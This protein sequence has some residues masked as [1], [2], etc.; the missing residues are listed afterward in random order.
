MGGSSLPIFTPGSVSMI[1]PSPHRNP[2]R[3]SHRTTL[4]AAGDTTSTSG[5]FGRRLPRALARNAVIA[6]IGATG[7]GAVMR[8]DLIGLRS[9]I[10]FD[11]LLH[12][13]S[14]TLYFG[15]G[16]LGLLAA[17]IPR[18]PRVT[19]VLERTATG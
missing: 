15:W 5:G 12:A 7:L 6:Y 1:V 17:A 14:H 2:Q 16:A 9:G 11:H 8:F 10:P 19:R 4:V 18:W 3:M 13:H